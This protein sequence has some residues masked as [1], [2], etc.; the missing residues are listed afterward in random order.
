MQQ[1]F[2]A[3]DRSH[4]EVY[5]AIKRYAFQAVAAGRK[6][7]GIA[8]IFERIRWYHTI[9]L[10]DGD[11]KLNNNFRAFYARKFAKE[12][13]QHAGLFSMR[14]SEADA[15]QAGRLADAGL[16]TFIRDMERRAS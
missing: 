1:A 2:E 8:L 14:S 12:F 15:P 13:P 5:E 16:A 7:I 4:P 3:F 11:F 9:E 10:S 6:R